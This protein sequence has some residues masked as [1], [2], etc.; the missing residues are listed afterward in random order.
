MKPSMQEVLAGLALLILGCLGGAMMVLP[1]PS[2]NATS[3]T[4][5]LGA[6]AGAL[7]V[8]GGNKIADKLTIVRSVT[9]K[10]PDHQQATYH[11][12]TGY[13]PTTVIDICIGPPAWH[14]NVARSTFRPE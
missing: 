6:L 3:L 4:F 11:L 8:T 13:T 1:I 14:E 10:I 9:G 12:Y 7:T 5:I 2:S